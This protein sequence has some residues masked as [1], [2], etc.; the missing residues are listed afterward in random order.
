[1]VLTI[2]VDL[3]SET[4]YLE[5][6]FA[7]KI[8]CKNYMTAKPFSTPILITLIQNLFVH[9]TN[10]IKLGKSLLFS[11]HKIFTETYFVSD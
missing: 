9:C 1:M 11:L 7:K 10:L 5:Y 6:L 2:M 4:S 8:F 3:F